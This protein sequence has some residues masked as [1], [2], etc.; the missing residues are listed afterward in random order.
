MACD[1]NYRSSD[2][3]E[4]DFPSWITW[5]MLSGLNCCGHAVSRRTLRNAKMMVY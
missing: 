1:L 5:P 2:L 3:K 4:T